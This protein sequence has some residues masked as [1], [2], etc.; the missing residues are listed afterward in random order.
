MLRF[1][2]AAF[3][4]HDSKPLVEE[5]Q[6]VD[7]CEMQNENEKISSLVL[8]GESSKCLRSIISIERSC[9]LA[10]VSEVSRLELHQ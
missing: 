8:I 7:D 6:S 9:L 4:S 10:E 3:A 2:E 1:G 5:N